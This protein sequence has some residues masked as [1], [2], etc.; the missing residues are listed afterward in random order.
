MCQRAH[1][2]S[3]GENVDAAVTDAG[4][5]GSSPLTRGKRHPRLRIGLPA[6]LIPAHAGKTPGRCSSPRRPWAHPRSRGENPADVERDLVS[7]G[8]SP[9]T[10]GKRKILLAVVA[11]VG[12]IP[13]HAGKTT[14]PRT[15]VASGAAH[16]R[17][18]G[19][20][21]R[22]SGAG[23]RHRGSSPLTR[24]KLRGARRRC[25]GVG[26]IPAH[27]GKTWIRAQGSDPYPAHPRSR[28]ENLPLPRRRAAPLGLIPAHAGKT[29]SSLRGRSQA[30]AHP[31]SR[32][33]NRQAPRTPHM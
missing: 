18:R 26:L 33:E 30:R 9:L 19:E 5:W 29:S 8:S 28:G 17:S 6:G 11:V 16:P 13:A 14:C 21:G 3:R 23:R 4:H 10:R 7:E 31:R 1:P 25:R 2:R 15:I 22:L 27:A 12:L 32:G 24:G 20:N